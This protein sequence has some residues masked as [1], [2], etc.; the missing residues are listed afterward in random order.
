MAEFTER[1][2]AACQT[3]TRGKLDALVTYLQATAS[4]RPVGPTDGTKHRWKLAIIGGSDYKEPVA[5]LRLPRTV[6]DR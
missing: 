2:D 6:I 4:D 1:V 5:K 3:V